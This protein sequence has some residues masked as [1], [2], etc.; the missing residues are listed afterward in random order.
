[1]AEVSMV[2]ENW[3]V[4][5]EVAHNGDLTF[6]VVKVVDSRPM[7]DISVT[8]KPGT[9]WFY[10]LLYGSFED[11]VADAMLLTQKRAWTLNEQVKRSIQ[12]VYEIG[13]QTRKENPH[14]D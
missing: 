8:V 1:M 11:R 10:N 5:H 3:F 2:P 4:K 12:L 13:K 9:S 14:D 7:A 6:T